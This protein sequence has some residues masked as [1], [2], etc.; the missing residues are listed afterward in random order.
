MYIYKV[1]TAVNIGRVLRDLNRVCYIALHRVLID[2]G[3]ELT[4]HRLSFD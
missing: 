1:K 4:I 2:N 3:K